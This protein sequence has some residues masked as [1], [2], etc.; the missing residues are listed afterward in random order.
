MS[1]AGG[2]TPAS[3]STLTLVLGIA[4]ESG[5]E[6]ETSGR[7]LTDGA[8]LGG[9]LGGLDDTLKLGSA[10]PL[11]AGGVPLKAALAVGAAA[12]SAVEAEAD[13]VGAADTI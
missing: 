4:L 1:T 7:A 8:E 2:L 10:A 6:A 5:D 9:E 3:L 11:D 12:E 13:C